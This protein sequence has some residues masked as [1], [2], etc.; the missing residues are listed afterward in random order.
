VEVPGYR[1]DIE[2]EAD[3]IEEVVRIQGYGRVGSSLPAIRQPGGVPEGYAFRD[4]LRRSLMRAG[5]REVRSF[6]FAS[7]DDLELFGDRD[8]ISIANPL[9]ADEAWLRTRLIPGL[10]DAIRRNVHR[11]VASASLFEVGTVFRLTDGRPQER[12]TAAF[13]MTGA[14]E[15]SWT[16]RRAYDFFDAKGA[17]EAMLSGLGVAWTEGDAAGHPFHPGRSAWVLVGGGPV[18]VVGELHPRVIEALDVLGRIAVAELEVEALQEHAAT[19]VEARDV[20]RFPPIHRDLAFIVDERTTHAQLEAAIR[21]AGGELVS[22]C[23]LF[24]V[25]AGPPLPAGKKSLAFSVDFRDL[26]RTLERETADEAVERIRLR[27]RDELGGV[28]RAG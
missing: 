14:A 11:Q 28:L 21:A 15:A 27:V 4:R 2:R 6:P 10:L 18:G 3:L 24:D 8:A 17:L 22:A 13:A 25:H 20:S 1:T 7:Q 5:L 23:V 9:D 12:L 19:T 26:D 16:G